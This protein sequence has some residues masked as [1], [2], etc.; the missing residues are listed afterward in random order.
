MSMIRK[1]HNHKL[2]TNFNPWHRE[3]ESH[4]NHDTARV[5]RQLYMGSHAQPWGEL[6]FQAKDKDF[7]FTYA[8]KGTLG[9]IC[10]NRTVHPSVCPSRFMSGAYLLYSLRLESPIW[11]VN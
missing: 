7:L 3:E 2:Q 10:S 6:S 4:N 1:C 9:G 8:P 11:C 5:V